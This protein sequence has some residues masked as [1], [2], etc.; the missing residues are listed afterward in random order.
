MKKVLLMIFSILMV[1]TFMGC[2]STVSP[3][4]TVDAMMTA[5]KEWDVE[6]MK[7]Y[8]SA[9]EFYSAA[10]MDMQSE[11]M[12]NTVKKLVAYM[13]YTITDTSA[14]KDSAVVSLQITNVD[15]KSVLSETL[16]QVLALA[17]SG[18]DLS[19]E[20]AEAKILELYSAAIE[21]NKTNLVTNTA[22]LNLTKTDDGWTIEK[23]SE[24]FFDA[25]FGGLIT[26]AKETNDLFSDDE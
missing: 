1:L 7:S 12:E 10:D 21:N 15:M 25:V 20:A 14:E 9:D 8:I 18:V 26:A 2:G 4:K 5:V 11:A 13:S 3:E 22:A 24:E 16:T 6:T 17:F 19:D 23:P